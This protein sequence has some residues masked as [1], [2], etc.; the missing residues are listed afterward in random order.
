MKTTVFHIFTYDSSYFNKYLDVGSNCLIHVVFN[1]VSAFNK[2]HLFHLCHSALHQ[3]V[4][5]GL[6]IHLIYISPFFIKT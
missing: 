1:F 3:T 5:L 6:K 2:S 4:D